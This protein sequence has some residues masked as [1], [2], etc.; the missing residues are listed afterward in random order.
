MWKPSKNP[1]IL[2]LQKSSTER[3]MALSSIPAPLGEDGKK[4]CVWC[5]DKLKSRH[6]NTR[7]CKNPLCSE[8]AWAWSYPQSENGLFFILQRQDWKC[9]G[10]QYDYR[11]FIQENV[12]GKSY[13]TKFFDFTKPNSYAMKS[14]KVRIAPELKPEVDHVVPI[15]KGGESLG[16]DNH[17]VICYTCHK[18]KTK[19][20]VSGKRK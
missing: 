11:A 2:E 3:S 18:A 20:D 5:G 8:M 1:K 12:I 13:G 16:L 14:L 10:C 6:P 7:Y 15:F 19:K 4:G 9:N 17:Q